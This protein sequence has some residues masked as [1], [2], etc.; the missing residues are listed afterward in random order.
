VRPKTNPRLAKRP[1]H[2]TFA[3]ARVV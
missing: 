2:G 1:V 3:I